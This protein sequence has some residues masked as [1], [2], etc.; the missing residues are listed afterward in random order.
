MI[1]ILKDIEGYENYQISNFGNVYSK[2][3]KRQLNPYL[4]GKKDYY[5]IDLNKKSFCVH[6]LVALAFLENLEEKE[7][8]DHRNGDKLDNSILN[9]R[10]AS[11]SENNANRKKQNSKSASKSI[12]KGVALRADGG[13][14]KWRAQVNH[15]GVH[16]SK[17]FLTEIKAAQ[18]YNEM[19][20]GFY[21]EF[22]LLNDV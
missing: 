8:I 15:G 6:R 13:K 2:K 22:A 20:K 17:C 10:W 1:E 11:R 21:G 19:V 12:Y 16:T 18:W 7:M 9:L 4:T 3:L 5:R 14:K